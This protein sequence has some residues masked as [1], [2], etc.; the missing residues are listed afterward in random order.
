MASGGCDRHGVLLSSVE[1]YDAFADSWTPMASMTKRKAQHCSV[2]V[3]NKM[4]VIGLTL[5]D[6]EVF[7]NTSK[8]FTALKTKFLKHPILNTVL[9]VG[10][11]VL[12]FQDGRKSVLC[13][14][15]VKRCWSK[16]YLTCK[17]RSFSCVKI[18]CI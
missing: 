1:S 17:A 15:V 5:N 14:D 6:F 16:K 9:S 12:V 7:D 8:T 13:Y 18:P 11:K 4:F 2:V 10:E 3:K